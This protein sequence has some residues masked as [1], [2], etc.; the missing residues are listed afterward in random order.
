MMNLKNIEVIENKYLMKYYHLLKS[1]EDEILDGFKTKESIKQDWKQFY[2]LTGGISEYSVGA[3]RILY[4]ILNGRNVNGSPNSAPVGSD[5]FFEHS[6]AFVHID[7]KTVGATL[8]AQKSNKNKNSKAWNNN[9][10]DYKESIFIGRNQNSYKGEI[11][12][13][14]GKSFEPPRLYNPSLPTYYNKNLSNEKIC[15]SYFINILYDKDTLDVLVMNI[16]SM[17][18]GELIKHYQSKVLQPG[19][20]KNQTRFRFNKC[21]NI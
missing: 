8:R 5:L 10:G 14:N 15:L 2:N 13:K 20:L 4:S 18:N 12:N 1:A 21:I 7:I 3:E 19:K 16:M 9:I 6:D 17:P 11:M